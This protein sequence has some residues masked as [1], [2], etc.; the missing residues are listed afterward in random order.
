MR[1]SPRRADM[2]QRTKFVDRVRQEGFTVPAEGLSEDPAG[3]RPFGASVERVDR[4]DQDSID[5]VVLALHA[6]SAECGG[7]YDGWE[8]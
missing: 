3:D 1:C 8:T 7:E 6:V 2:E 4:V 5:Q